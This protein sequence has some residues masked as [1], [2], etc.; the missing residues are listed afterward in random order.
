MPVTLGLG[1]VAYRLPAGHALRLAVA[2]SDAPE[3]VPAPGTGEH[4]LARRHDQNQSP[5][6]APGRVPSDGL[7]PGPQLDRGA[8]DRRA[9]PGPCGAGGG[10]EIE[11]AVG[12]LPPDRP[13]L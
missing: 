6:A 2:S 3:F 8:G 13:E 9:A 7:D 10:A 11:A 4:R 5:D 1:H 12:V